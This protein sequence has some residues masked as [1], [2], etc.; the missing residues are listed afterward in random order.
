MILTDNFGIN[1]PHL[2]VKNN[3]T[4]LNLLQKQGAPSG[5]Y[6]M[7]RNSKKSSN[8]T[9][10]KDFHLGRVSSLFHNDTKNKMFDWIHFQ[11][12]NECF[13]ASRLLCWDKRRSVKQTIQSC[14]E[15]GSACCA[16]RYQASLSSMISIKISTY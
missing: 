1:W 15:T 14:S 8:K 5:F 2:N 7:N 3:T 12:Q 4:L 11:R 10:S 16:S 6:P 9:L 13:K